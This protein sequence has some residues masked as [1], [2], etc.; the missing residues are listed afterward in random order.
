M[1]VGLQPVGTACAFSGSLHG[2]ELVPVKWRCL[3][4]SSRG[5]MLDR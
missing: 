2:F 3:V 5:V 1:V 4:P